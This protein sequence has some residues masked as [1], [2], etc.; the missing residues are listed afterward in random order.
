MGHSCCVT[1]KHDMMAEMDNRKKRV[2]KADKQLVA[3]V[4]ASDQQ[5]GSS[6]SSTRDN[7]GGIDVNGMQQDQN[8]DSLNVRPSLV[9]SYMAGSVIDPRMSDAMPSGDMSMQDRNSYV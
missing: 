4:G 9:D 6:Q 7:F 8:R 3:G 1:K 2:T 5:L